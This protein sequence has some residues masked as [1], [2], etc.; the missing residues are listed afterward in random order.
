LV[1]DLNEKSS[2]LPALTNPNG[3]RGFDSF[4]QGFL[5]IKL[6]DVKERS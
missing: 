5:L 4:S 6:S 2:F 1:A 3:S